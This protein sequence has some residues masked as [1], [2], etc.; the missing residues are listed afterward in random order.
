MSL[1]RPL[2]QS[3]TWTVSSGIWTQADDPISNNDNRQNKCA[4]VLLLFLSTSYFFI[5]LFHS[6]LPHLFSFPSSFSLYFSFFS[7]SL[8]PPLSFSLSRLPLYIFLSLL[9]FFSFLSFFFFNTLYLLIVP[10]VSYHCLTHSRGTFEIGTLIWWLNCRMVF[11]CISNFFLVF[12][13]HQTS[14][15]DLST[16]VIIICAVLKMVY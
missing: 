11:R 10:L 2:A 7:L 9:L 14:F 12:A 15:V 8:S 3:K 13:F 4:S 16:V 5:S 6:F 1:I